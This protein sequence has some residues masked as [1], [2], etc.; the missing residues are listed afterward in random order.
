MQFLPDEI[1]HPTSN[2][3]FFNELSLNFQRIDHQTIYKQKQRNPNIVTEPILS[4]LAMIWGV[5]S[6]D[7][8][9]S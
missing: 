5:L 1:S 2:E 4:D 9:K 7:L 3:K 8:N 6:S